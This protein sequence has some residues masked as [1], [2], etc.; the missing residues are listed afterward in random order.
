MGSKRTLATID[1][2]YIQDNYLELD[3]QFP[4]NSQRQNYFL[5]TCK[6]LCPDI[7]IEEAKNLRPYGGIIGMDNS[8]LDR[9]LRRFKLLRM[10]AFL[11]D[12][13]GFVYDRAGQGPGY[14]YILPCATKS[15]L[16]GH[17][18][19]ILF[20]FYVKIFHPKLFSTL[21]C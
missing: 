11:H 14:T 15:C 19:G 7:D 1:L 4:E 6:Y 16:A 21:N 2:H 12:A 8:R 10:H 20:C 5:A 18:S 3:R 9:P 13:A 17:V